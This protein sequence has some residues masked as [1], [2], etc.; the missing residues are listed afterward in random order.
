MSTCRSRRA[1]DMG[2]TGQMSIVARGRGATSLAAADGHRRA[3]HRSAPGPRAH[4]IACRRDRVGADASAR[5]CDHQRRHGTRGAVAG[6]DGHLRCHGVYGRA[7]AP[8]VRH[9]S[10]ARGS[11][12]ARRPDGVP[13]GHV[14]RGSWPGPRPRVSRSAS[15]RSSPPSSTACRLLTCQPFSGQWRSSSPSARRRPSCRRVR[16]FARDGVARFNED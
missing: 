6:V 11:T 10:R 12:R 7:Q 1:S 9:S 13:A 4:G 14:A 16:R 5:P 3:G 15:G 8:G 2:M